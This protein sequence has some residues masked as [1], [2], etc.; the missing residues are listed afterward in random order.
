MKPAEAAPPDSRR[1]RSRRWAWPGWLAQA[2]TA[3]IFIDH[4]GEGPPPL[5]AVQKKET[6]PTHLGCVCHFRT[7]VGSI[8]ANRQE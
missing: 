5:S 8:F 3:D 6:E 4:A 2:T 1:S 7:F